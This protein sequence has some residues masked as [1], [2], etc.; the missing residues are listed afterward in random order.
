MRRS[1]LHINYNGKNIT[2]SLMHYV[3]DLSYTDAAS[4]ELDDLSITVS[5]RDKRWINAWSPI[6]GDRVHAAVEVFDWQHEGQIKKLPFGVFYVDGLIFTG[7]PDII[8][9]KAASFPVTAEIKQVKRSKVW[10]EVKL[11]T[12]AYDIAKRAGLKLVREVG[13]DA[14]YDRLE[15]D[16]Q[17]D[18]SFLLEQ[19]KK[20]GIACKVVE[21]KLVL[22]D[23]AKFE[24]GKS[25]ATYERG[26]DYLLDYSFDWSSSNCAYRACEVTYEVTQ[27]GKKKS[28]TMKVTYTPPGAPKTGPILRV[29]ENAKS[30][31]DALRI[32]KNRLRE[33]NKQANLVS[34]TVFGDIRIATGVI[35]TIK[36][37]GRFDGKYVVD[38]AVHQFNSSGYKTKM[39]IRKVLGW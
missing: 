23:E 14:T 1:K 27:K 26:K 5:D 10:E 2:E 33:K 30:Q 12:I 37:F 9:I 38:Q 11:S 13:T 4:G 8:E 31:A 19:T 35:V 29:K 20:E 34:I 18:F 16:E 15:Q 17:T 39:N 3:I 22:F 21:G 7:P 36:G 28:T 25:V 24:K 6:E 32:G